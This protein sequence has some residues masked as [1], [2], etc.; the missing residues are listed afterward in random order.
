VGVPPTHGPVCCSIGNKP[1]IN[2]HLDITI[3]VCI[4]VN[5]DVSNNGLISLVKIAINN[6]KEQKCTMYIGDPHK[7]PA[8]TPDS[9]NRAKPKSAENNT[10][11]QQVR[12]N[13]KKTDKV[14]T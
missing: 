12:Y 9:R 7:V 6:D 8:I 13:S 5:N 10:H 1:P 3:K 4:V 14:A 11:R 2:S